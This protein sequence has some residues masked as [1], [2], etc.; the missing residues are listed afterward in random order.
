[1]T[2]FRCRFGPRKKIFTTWPINRLVNTHFNVFYSFNNPKMYYLYTLS[3]MLL[4]VQ[5][6]KGNYTGDVISDSIILRRKNMVKNT[7]DFKCE[8]LD[9]K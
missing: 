9:Y 8:Y 7:I 6:M 4:R 3:S 5:I 1:M 2:L